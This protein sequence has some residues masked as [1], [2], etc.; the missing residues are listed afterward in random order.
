MMLIHFNSALLHF[1]SKLVSF[2]F[3]ETQNKSE[4]S[5]EMTNGAVTTFLCDITAI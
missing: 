2:H 3:N 5:E 1:L 4:I